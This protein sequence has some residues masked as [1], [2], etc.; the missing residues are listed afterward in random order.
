MRLTVPLVALGLLIPSCAP[1]VV[2][3]QTQIQSSVRVEGRLIY[4]S[5][6]NTGPRDLLL[7]NDCPRP[8]ALKVLSAE[9]TALPD[10]AYGQLQTCVATALPP[11][12]WRVGD[13]IMTSVEFQQL[14]GEYNLKAEANMNVKLASEGYGPDGFK[15]LKVN[16]APFVVTLR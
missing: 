11:V 10:S 16:V 5:L 12:L 3:P 8:F 4:V 14:P 6:L 13:T 2:T 15:P 1:R 9:A 7:K